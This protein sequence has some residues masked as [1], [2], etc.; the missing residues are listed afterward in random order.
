MLR[1]LSTIIACLVA[2]AASAGEFNGVL[3]IGDSA[4]AWTDL[5]GTDG[6]SHSLAD[7]K[8]KK[9]VVV[10]FTCNSCPVAR[11]YED[12]IMALAKQNPQDVAVVAINVNRGA[13]D[14]L[15]KMTERAQ[16]RG[17]PYLYLADETQNIGRAYGASATPDFFVLSP[18]R[19]IVYMG[20]L[21]DNN[22]AA[23]AKV[24][25]VADAV[26]AAL[27]GTKAATGETFARGCGIRYAR[28]RSK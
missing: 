17:F 26:R 13:E 5:P 2:T 16:E 3:N 25:Y 14:S 7:L 24:N 18:D 8:D 4:P 9:T 6:K 27:A 19:K 1:T 12:R 11:D 20:S 28:Q 23:S 22:D 15:A 21:D 10:V